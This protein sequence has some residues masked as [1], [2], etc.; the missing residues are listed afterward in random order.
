[1]NQG[2]KL[3]GRGRRKERGFT[4]LEYCAG[5]AVLLIIIWVAM[6][7][8]GNQVGGL[9]EEIGQWSTKQAQLISQTPGNQ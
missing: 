6:R 9:L 5:A 4:L 2:N 3:N 7:S 8:M 1:M